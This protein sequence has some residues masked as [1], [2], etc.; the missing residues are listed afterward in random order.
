MYFPYYTLPQRNKLIKYLIICSMNDN[1]MSYPPFKY[2]TNFID[3]SASQ[4]WPN[5]NIQMI[6]CP[7]CQIR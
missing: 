4:A 1:T 6:V 2:Y 7:K 5:T 3:T